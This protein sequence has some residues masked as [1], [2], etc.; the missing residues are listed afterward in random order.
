MI[1]QILFLGKRAGFLICSSLNTRFSSVVQILFWFSLY[2]A[3]T[4]LK[5]LPNPSQLRAERG[6]I[7]I[8][9]AKSR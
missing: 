7:G 6:T 5:R 8:C 1:L 9:L 2:T 4:I 3:L